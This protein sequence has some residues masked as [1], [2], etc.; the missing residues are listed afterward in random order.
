[1]K[2]IL[3]SSLVAAA[4]YTATGAAQAYS[5]FF[6]EDLNPGG[7][8]V[9][10]ASIPNSAAAETSFKA[11]LLGVGTET[12]ESK[13]T[14]AG[15]PLTIEFAGSVGTLQ[16]TLS[17]GGFV[18]GVTPG[19]TDGNGRYSIPSAT[20]SKFWEVN[21]EGNGFTVSFVQE[22][23]AFGFYA[24]DIG[25]FGGQMTVGLLNAAD[26]VISTMNVNNTPG[27][28]GSTDGS[29]LYFGLIASNGSE[30]F[31]K[32]RFDT[33]S[34]GTSDL[35][36]FDSFTIAELSQVSPVPEPGSLALMAAGLLGLTL[37]R[38]HAQR[39]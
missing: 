20:S 10:L 24:V 5:Q 4:A 32:V 23:A 17:A 31:R 2:K 25:D 18:R 27:V 21:A 34:S 35:F 37:A 22:I 19:S 15:G 33:T 38:R 9:P 26:E 6:G 8:T 13:T 16:A 14:G 3:V 36:A 29:V 11:N 28:L 39:Q 7:P 30:T 1:M 12:F